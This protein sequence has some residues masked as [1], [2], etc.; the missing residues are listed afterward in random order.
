MDF[1]RIALLVVPMFIGLGVMIAVLSWT[2]R[3]RLAGRKSPLTQGLLRPAGYSLRVQFDDVFSDVM[4]WLMMALFL[5]VVVGALYSGVLLAPGRGFSW[6]S[7]AIY[8]TFAVSVI[9]VSAYRAVKSLRKAMNLRMGWDAEMAT[10][11]ELDQLM[12]SGA[13]VFHDLPAKEFN[14]DHVLIC[15]SGV[16]AVETK[17]RLK[18]IAGGK[19]GAKVMCEGTTLSFPDWKDSSTVEQAQ[20]QAKWLS[21]ELTKAVGEPVRVLGVVALPGWFVVQ[22]GR[23]EVKV[24]NPKNFRYLLDARDTPLSPV[25]MTRVAY[26]VEQ[27]CRDVAPAY[28]ATTS[29]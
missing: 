14:I 19:E 21:S 4:G 20:R 23:Y 29:K 16:Y 17:S 15:P 2:R 24:L 8:F 18:A 13:A 11:Q 6:T 7:A 10:G 22:N 26:Q 27:W 1:I 3:A 5:P 9:G 12:R 25:L 28:S